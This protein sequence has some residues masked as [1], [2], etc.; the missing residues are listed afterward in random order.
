MFCIQFLMGRLKCR[1]KID[2][3][4]RMRSIVCFAPVNIVMHESRM[5]S[6]TSL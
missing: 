6:G 3:D 2:I 4:T 1:S 5:H